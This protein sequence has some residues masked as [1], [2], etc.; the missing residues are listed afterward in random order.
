M[1]YHILFLLHVTALTTKCTRSCI[2]D[3]QLP[4]FVSQL[5]TEIFPSFYFDICDDNRSRAR[6]VDIATGY[7]LDD[8]EV[9]VSPGRVSISSRPALGSTQPPIYIQCVLRI[10][11]AGKAAGA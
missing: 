11:P 5:E 6:V 9:G 4:K 3:L 7:R 1:A 10:F 8:R 2:P